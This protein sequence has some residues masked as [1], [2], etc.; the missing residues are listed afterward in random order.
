MI[1][2][3]CTNDYYDRSTCHNRHHKQQATSLSFFL[4]CITDV[5][6]PGSLSLF[7][8]AQMSLCSHFIWHGLR[9]IGACRRSARATDVEV[10]DVE[11]DENSKDPLYA[12]RLDLDDLRTFKE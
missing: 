12:Q 8:P 7:L 11:R 1:I 4:L 5:G 2:E 9:V 10:H 6:L 3:V